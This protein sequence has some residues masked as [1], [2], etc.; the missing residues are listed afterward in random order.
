[1]VGSPR[2]ARAVGRVM[3]TAPPDSDTPC[4]RVVRGDG[5]VVDEELAR[6]LRDEGV[7]VWDGQ[8]LGFDVVRWAQPG[9]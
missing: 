3:T 7:D 2:A 5:S 6:R 8:V 9:D 4:H 1:A